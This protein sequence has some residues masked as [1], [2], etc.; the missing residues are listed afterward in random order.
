MAI[1]GVC[2][3]T[4]CSDKVKERKNALKILVKKSEEEKI[5]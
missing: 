3:L 1:N 5:V 2:H 4:A